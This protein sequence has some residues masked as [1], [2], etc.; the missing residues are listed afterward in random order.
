MDNIDAWTQVITNPLGLAGFALFLV[1]S[2]LAKFGLKNKPGW[3]VVVAFMMALIALV[4]GLALAW[5]QH[6]AVDVNTE[7]ISKQT[8]HSKQITHGAKS[9]AIQNVEGDVIINFSEEE[10]SN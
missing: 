6:S 7:S 8:T 4:G 3:M 2:L 5:K 1:F 10:T 9:P